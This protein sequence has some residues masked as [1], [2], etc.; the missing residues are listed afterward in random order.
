MKYVID[1]SVAFKWLQTEPDS[2]KADR[3]RS[4]YQSGVDELIAPELFVV[5]MSNITIMAERR[6]RIAT[7]DGTLLLLDLATTMPRLIFGRP[8][9]HRRAYEIAER[10]GCTVYDCLYVALAEEEGCLVITA[11]QRFVN[12]LL[13]RFPLARLLSTLP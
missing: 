11:D 5:E 9:L 1:S 8:H 6:G 12:G 10:T 7:G 13:P 4:N 2:D 3:L